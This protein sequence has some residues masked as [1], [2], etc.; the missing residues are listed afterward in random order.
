M[1][2]PYGNSISSHHFISSPLS[3][4]FGYEHITDTDKK[5]IWQ[6]FFK[7]KKIKDINIQQQLMEKTRDLLLQKVAFSLIP[8]ID[9]SYLSF[10]SI[11]RDIEIIM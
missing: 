9:T 10:F 6:P 7:G 1:T 11:K 2:W 4:S 8:R 3:S 5:Q